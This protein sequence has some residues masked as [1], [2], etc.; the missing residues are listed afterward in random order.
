VLKK[1]YSEFIE[2]IDALRRAQ[3]DALVVEDS[4][5]KSI[6]NVQALL[7]SRGTLQNTQ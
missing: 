1:V 7:E 3:L 4:K 5:G 6:G 2:A